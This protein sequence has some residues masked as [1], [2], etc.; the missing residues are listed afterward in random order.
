M[1]WTVPQYHDTF[2]IEGRK[3]CFHA[4]VVPGVQL[5][6]YTGEPPV[7]RALTPVRIA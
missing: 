7:K 5:A 4:G 6:E 3:Y 2:D 1:F